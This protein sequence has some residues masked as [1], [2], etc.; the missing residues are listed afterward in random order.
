MNMYKLNLANSNG[1][2]IGIIRSDVDDERW[3]ID[4]LEKNT[5]FRDNW[6]KLISKS[7]LKDKFG[8]GT[9]SP[10]SFVNLPNFKAYKLPYLVSTGAAMTTTYL[11]FHN[12]SL[13]LI[14]FKSSQSEFATNLKSF[15]ELMTL[16]YF[17]ESLSFCQVKKLGKVNIVNKSANPYDLYKNGELI[18]T[19]KGKAELSIYAPIGTT[20]YRA[21]QKSG[22]MMYPTE[23]KRNVIIKNACQNV[24]IEIGFEDQ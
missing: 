6:T 19:I 22:Y 20:N 15:E 7:I 4:F 16:F 21:I 2:E 3:S 24:S 14:Y 18:E 13:Y 9:P 10:A 8:E 5:E 23:N 17:G 12:S 1:F 11:T